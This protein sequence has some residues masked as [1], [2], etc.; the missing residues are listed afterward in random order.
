VL[1]LYSKKH[2]VLGGDD[3]KTTKTLRKQRD[4]TDKN[5]IIKEFTSGAP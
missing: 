1:Q 5:A 4:L 3:L 2:G